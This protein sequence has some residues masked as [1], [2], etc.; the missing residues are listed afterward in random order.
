M[1]CW[2]WET[3]VDKDGRKKE[4]YKPIN[5][6]KGKQSPKSKPHLR[7]NNANGK[8]RIN[9]TNIYSATVFINANHHKLSKK[10]KRNKIHRENKT[11]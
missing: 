2:F 6:P 8:N 9:G 5:I 7:H 4:A 11:M 1:I 3:V 10:R